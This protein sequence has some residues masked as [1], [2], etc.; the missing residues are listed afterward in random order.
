MAAARF[1]SPGTGAEAGA[2]AEMEAAFQAAAGTSAAA[3][4]RA[5]GREN[6][7]MISDSEK[8]D[9]ER[10]ITKAENRTSAESSR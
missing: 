10:A 2:A 7:I 6:A 8:L 9:V 3:A 5:I 4:H 1:S